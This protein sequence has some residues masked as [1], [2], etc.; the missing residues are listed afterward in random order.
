MHYIE[1]ERERKR[2]RVCVCARARA[3]VRWVG[4]EELVSGYFL[5][6]KGKEKWTAFQCLFRQKHSG[7]PL[8]QEEGA[9]LSYQLMMK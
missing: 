3:L 7:M 6:E 1:R 2:V 8:F 5:E 9:C 4:Q